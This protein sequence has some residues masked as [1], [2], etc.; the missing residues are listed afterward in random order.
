MAGSSAQSVIVVGAGIAGLSA[1]R[2]LQRAGFEVSVYERAADLAKVQI[3]GGFHLWTN[4]MRALRELGLDQDAIAIGSPIERTEYRTYVGDMMA[5]WPVG[6]IAADHGIPDIGVN[7]R[8]LHRML[9]EA[10]PEGMVQLGKE[11][12]GFTEEGYGVLVRFK[13]GTEVRASALLGADGLRSR[14][15]AQLHGEEKPRPAGYTQWQTTIGGCDDLL[16]AGAEQVIF[17]PG[18]RAILHYVGNGELFWAGV[19]YGP[20]ERG[21]A[22]RGP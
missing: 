14:V 1:A 2:A 8:D 19:L 17:G 18:S 10:L 15:R 7:R 16:Q 5:M 11:L 13:D 21:R 4:A 20:T 22:A 9:A 12:E 3:G 6:E